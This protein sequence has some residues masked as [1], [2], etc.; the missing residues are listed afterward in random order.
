VALEL[1]RD[2]RI[3][4]LTTVWDGSR[5]DTSIMSTLLEQTIE[6]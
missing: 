1:D 5:I 6:Q 4:R 2:A 3:T